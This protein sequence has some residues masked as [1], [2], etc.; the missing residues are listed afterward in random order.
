MLGTLCLQWKGV[1]RYVMY[2]D[3][4]MIRSKDDPDYEEANTLV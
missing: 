1:T 2:V 4:K 3:G